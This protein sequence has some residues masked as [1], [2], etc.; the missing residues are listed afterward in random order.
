MLFVSGM[1]HNTGHEHADEL[2]FELFEFG[3]RIIVDSGKYGYEKDEFRKYVRSVRAHNTVSLLDQHLGPADTRLTG[4]AL[5]PVTTSEGTFVIPGEIERGDAL[6]HQRELAYRP[7]EFLLITDRVRS[8]E[9]P[10]AVLFHVSHTLNVTREESAFIIHLSDGGRARL[11]MLEGSCTGTLI[12]GQRVPHVQGWESIGYLQM[13]PAP[14][15]RFDCA[16]GDRMVQ[17]LISFGAE[18]RTEALRIARQR[19]QAS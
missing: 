16:P 9:Q 19:Q 5:S 10:F 7:R 17:T 12:E 15:V 6:R 2:S 8:G 4:S 1:A 11:E 18:A 3:E 14:T 13:T